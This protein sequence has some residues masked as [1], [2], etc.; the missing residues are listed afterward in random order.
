VPLRGTT[1]QPDRA[2]KVF[3]ALVL[4]V[5]L[6]LSTCT[7]RADAQGQ[8]V[9]VPR[10]EGWPEDVRKVVSHVYA[11]DCLYPVQAEEYWTT[12]RATRW[13]LVLAFVW[14]VLA[15]VVLRRKPRDRNR[16]RRGAR[17]R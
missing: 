13:V 5:A 10:K 9:Y 16:W 11:F 17:C 12:Y 8:T 1:M 6:P 4:L 3:A 2:L 14:P 15:L 7:Y